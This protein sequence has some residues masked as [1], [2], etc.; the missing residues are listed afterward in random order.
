M[1]YHASQTRKILYLLGEKEVMI[2]EKHEIVTSKE[3]VRKKY[4]IIKENTPQIALIAPVILAVCTVISDYYCY[5]FNL[6][7][8]SYFGIDGKFML[9]YNKFNLYQY[10]KQFVFVMLYWGYSIFAVRMVLLEK[11]YLWK[12]LSMIVIPFVVGIFVTYNGQINTIMLIASFIFGLAQWPMIFFCGFWLVKSLHEDIL[13]E[14][15]HNEKREKERRKQKKD[16]KKTRWGNTEYGMLGLLLI[17]GA[18]VILFV[19]AYYINYMEASNQREFG[20]I[21]IESETYAVIDVVEDK[22]IV[23]KCKLDGENLKIDKGTY[24]CISNDRLINFETFDTVVVEEFEKEVAQENVIANKSCTIDFQVKFP[25]KRNVKN[26]HA[27][28]AGF[29]ES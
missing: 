10:V 5:W 13:K 4:Q 27:N 28:N 26:V 14:R 29:I 17:G 6:G 9:T 16:N 1:Y 23:Q 18:I 7:Y 8:Y 11:N 22:M 2:N 19:Q 12:F 15:K 21:D 20:I 3:I 25:M 24:L